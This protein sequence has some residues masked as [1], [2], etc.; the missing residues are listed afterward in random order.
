MR[1]KRCK[2]PTAHV[3]TPEQ[4]ENANQALKIKNGIN[5]L[6]NDTL[7][8]ATSDLN[9]SLKSTTLNKLPVTNAHTMII[10]DSQ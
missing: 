2:R 7:K 10:A 1:A 3:P 9:S 8:L 5:K 6:V 4:D